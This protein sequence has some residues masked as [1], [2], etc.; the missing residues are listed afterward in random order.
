VLSVLGMIL[1]ALAG[2]TAARLREPRT[3]RKHEKTFPG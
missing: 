1:I 2:I 3:V